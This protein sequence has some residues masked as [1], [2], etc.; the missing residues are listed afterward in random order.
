MSKY[1][2]PEKGRAKVKIRGTSIGYGGKR[3]TWESADSSGIVLGQG[4]VFLSVSML[5][6][7]DF[8]GGHQ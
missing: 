8:N 5:G 6:H 4:D 7:P 2:Q 1:H 3:K